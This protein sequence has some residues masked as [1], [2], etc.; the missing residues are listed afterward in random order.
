MEENFSTPQ[1]VALLMPAKAQKLSSIL[2]R[3]SAFDVNRNVQHFRQERAFLYVATPFLVPGRRNVNMV[4]DNCVFAFANRLPKACQC[5]TDRFLC[6]FASR[7]LRNFKLYIP[8]A[9]SDEKSLAR[10]CV[11]ERATCREGVCQ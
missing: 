4:R 1:S 2:R 8:S 7:I 10:L 9:R 3:Q 5:F 11:I 6:A